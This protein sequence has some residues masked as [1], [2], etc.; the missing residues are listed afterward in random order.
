MNPPCEQCT[1][2]CCKQTTQPAAVMLE[3]Y[4]IDYESILVNDCLMGIVRAIPYVNNKCFYLTDNKCSIYDRRPV[5][6]REFNCVLGYN[7]NRFSFFLE[8]HP[9][10]VRLIELNLNLLSNKEI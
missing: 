4:E 7:K 8:D 3:E 6:C 1:A 5:R 10:V 2:A 9:D